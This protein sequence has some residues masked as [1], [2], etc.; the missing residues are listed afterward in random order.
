LYE[1]WE[2]FKDLQWQCP[3]RG[4]PDWLLVQTFYNELEHSVKISVDA[5]VGGALMRKL[6]E[7]AKAL[8]EEMASNN[9]HLSTERAIPKRSSGRYEVDVATLLTSRWMRWHKD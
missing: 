4:A 3:H 6:I 5:A 2:R 1:A 9:Y 7:A 8:L